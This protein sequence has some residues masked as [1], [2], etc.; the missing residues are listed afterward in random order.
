MRWWWPHAHFKD[1]SRRPG[2]GL[3]YLEP[4][5]V[6]GRTGT[7]LKGLGLSRVL[8]LLLKSRKN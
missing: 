1:Q 3:L 6:S 4:H 2:A 8:F 5:D 7:R